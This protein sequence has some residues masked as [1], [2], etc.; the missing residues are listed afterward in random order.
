MK[1]LYITPGCFDKG[2]IS[3]YS[4]YQITALRELYGNS[5][6]RVLSLLGQQKGDFEV[7]FEVFWKGKGADLFSKVI[8]ILLTTWLLISWRPRILH[9]AHINFSGVT[10]F[11]GKLFGATTIL[12]IY[13]LEIWSNPSKDALYGLRKTD[14]IISDCHYTARFVKENKLREKENVQVIWDCVDME[15]FFPAIPNVSVLTSYGI[16]DP[17]IHF[18]I[19]TLGRLTKTAAHKGYDRLIKAFAKLG[20]EFPQARLV[21][22]GKGDQVDYYKELAQTEGILDSVIFTGMV[23]E[24]DLPDIYRSASVFSLVSDRGL[25]RGEGIPLTPLEAMACGIPVMVGNQDGSQEAVIDDQNGYIIDPFDL[26]QQANI[27]KEL[28]N[29]PA[30]LAAKKEMAKKISTEYFSF[31]DFLSKTKFFYE[32]L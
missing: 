32:N 2:G 16:P 17:S 3:R 6:V 10:Y 7:P 29:N 27:F 26:Q 8:M 9:T 13:G 15:R 28:I 18:N 24:K 22:A 23:A 19:L 5:N 1:I 11:L 12:N 20:S 4:R 30:I 21:I 25:N 14:C 31:K